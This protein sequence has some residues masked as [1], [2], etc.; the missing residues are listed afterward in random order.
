MTKKLSSVCAISLVFLAVLG[1][2]AT[3]DGQTWTPLN[4]A[5]PVSVGAMLLLTDGRVLVHEEPNCSG[6]GCVSTTNAYN[7]WYTLTPDSTGSY[8]NGTWAQVASTPTSPT[9]Y[10]P[11]FFSSAV[12]PDGKVAIQG[13]EYNCPSANCAD[14][15]QSNGALYDPAANTWTAITPE[16]TSSYEA[17]GDAQ[18]VVLPN[19]TW[20]TAACCAY[21]SGHASFPEYYYFNESSLNFTNEA[22]ASDGE[23]TEFDESGWNLMPNGEVLMVNVYLGQYGSG[24]ADG[25]SIYNP[26]TNT[27][28][29]YSSTA[30]QLWDSGC[31]NSS[32]A[33]YELGP[34]M[35]M[36]NG[37]FF[38]TGASECEA[39]NIAT[40]NWSTNTWTAQGT[41]PNKNAA[42]DAPGATEINGNAIV[43]T[44][45]Y[46]NTFSSPLTIYEWNGTTL[47]TFPNVSRASSDS[48]YVTHLLVL[49]TGQIMFTDFSTTV[50]ILTSAGTYESA[51]Q[52]TISSAPF[53]LTAGQTYSIS[54]TQFNGVSTGASYGDDFQDNTNYPL[55]RIVNNGTGDVYYARTHGHSTMGVATG[56]TIVSTNFDVPAGMPSGPCELYVVGNGIPSAASPCDVGSGTTTTL[57]L[58]SSVNPSIF[59]Q[60]VTFTA[61][62]TPVNSPAPT[63]TVQFTANGSGITGCTAVTL[64]SGTAQ[65]ATAGLAIGTNAI[66]A[67][68]SGDSNYNGTTGTLSGGQI[69][70]QATTTTVVTSSGNPSV[71]E[72]SVTMTAT[73]S[74]QYGQVKGR[75]GQAKSQNI[76]GT[77]TWS[78]NTGCSASTVTSGNPGT[79]TCTTSSLAVGT[80]TITAT[81]SG[82]NNHSGSSGTLGQVV[83]Q[84]S[85]T[86]T[87]TTN[88][89]A[90]KVYNGS[91]TVAAT[92]SSGLAVTFT[93]A[94]SCSNSGAT[95]TMTSGAGTCSVIAN[96]AGNA[97]YS[98]AAQVTETTN[99]TLASQTITFTTPAPASAGYGNSFTVV[100]NGGGSGNSLVFTSSGSCSNSGTTY[101]MTS[102]TGTCSVIANQA[103]NGNYAAAAQVT[104]TTTAILATSST[105]VSSSAN[106]SVYSQPVT[107]TA[108]ISGQYGQVKG[109]K[110]QAKPQNLSGTVTWSGNTGCGTTTVTSG[111]PGTATC[112]TSSLAVGTDAITATYSGDSNHNGNSSTLS[113]GQVVSQAST[114]ATVGSSLNPSTYGQAVSFT[115][116]VAAV[117]PAGG[118]PTG[119]VQFT[120]DG[121]NVGSPVTLAS[122]SATSG[123]TSTLAEGTHTITAVYSGVTDYAAS[124]GTLSAGQT[125]NQAT[126]ATVV[127]SS[128]NPSISGQSVT[129]T[130]TI[131]GQYGLVK[132]RKGQAKSRNVTGTVAWSGNTGCSASTVTSGNPGTATCTTSTLPVG[133]DGITA[134]YSGD[135]NHAGS[136]GTLSEVVN[137]ATASTTTT[138]GSS[139]DPSTY[140]QAVSF[141][142]TVT[143]ATGTPTGTVQFSIDGGAFGS[144]A[145][146]VSGSATSGSIATLT[147]GTH[148][149]TAVYS[150]DTDFA[151]STGALGGGQVVSQ[152]TAATVVTSSVNPS[153]FGQSVTLTATI[154]GENGQV[155]R[156]GSA[157]PEN[158]TG[159]V[160]WSS[161]TGCGTTSV[162]SGNPGVATC[163]TTVLPV[164]N[165]TIT[166][167]YLG[168]SNHGSSTGTLSGGQ[169]VNPATASTTT[170]VG[171][172]LNPSTYGQAVSFTANVASGAGTP[173]G[174][175][176]FSIDGSAF[177]S[178]VTLASGSATSGSTSTLAEGTHTVTAVYAG[179]VGFGTSTGTL[180]GGQV[181]NQASVTMTVGSSVNPSVYAQSVTLTA[182]IGG[183]YG[184]V[185]SNGRKR[186]DVSGTV[187]WST[188][189]GCGT[190]TVTPGN[191]GVATCTTSSFGVGTYA[192]TATYSGDSNHNGSS[193]TLAG[194]QVVN[195]A[196]QTITVT[197]PAPATAT[198][199]SS[200]TVVASASS[201]LAITFTSAGACTNAGAT[202]TMNSTKVGA[203][204]VVGIGQAGNADY[205]AASV[206]ELTN[207]AAAIAP[208]VTFTGA[209]ASDTYLS[210]FTVATT[211]NAS[212][213][214]TITAAPSTVC[215]ISGNVVTMVNGTGT[216]T[217]TAAWAADD[218]YKAATATQK[219]IAAKASSGLAWSTPAAITYGTLLSS[220]Q[221]DATANVAGTFV[222]S[223]AAGTKPKVPVAP[224]TCDTLKVTFTPTLATDYTKQT[225]TV[226]LVVNP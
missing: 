30:V 146:L 139:S 78:S 107:L 207:V 197:V 164:G 38:A 47:S 211:T 210:T 4:N 198:N 185:K 94:G 224:A 43:V 179:V 115:A 142:A 21:Y 158:V 70:N 103:G 109:R 191:P 160:A 53:N 116:N 182:T 36:P 144:P 14:A 77:V 68:Y 90:S 57:A 96:Q 24:T 192:I 42:N 193:A 95:Y 6:S 13:G 8:I 133:T 149:V 33:S 206:T 178:P 208:T 122:G 105:A 54:G 154:S 114:N 20:M 28:T 153:V 220:V 168:D 37:T 112:T 45:P 147:Q 15:W 58:S 157:K 40:Y 159:S 59:G 52:P 64:T 93:S 163:T 44:S 85:Q 2:V 126:A 177:G 186:Q 79:A 135:S 111:T 88:A 71:F 137:Q 205:A 180:S 134:T 81:Y 132:G 136:T 72:Q 129:L 123:S 218:K 56:S 167:T 174:T 18:S 69:V 175:V 10:A 22:S 200:F 35:L 128:A 170:T 221:L 74:G 176:Q 26:S 80:D 66:V 217:L 148:T 25:Y 101:T 156:N 104:E 99:A 75:K 166:A 124:T 215:T 131:S 102:G 62:V 120:V 19:G 87:F 152:A 130:A 9:N 213:T 51:W 214:P 181:V 46:T 32:K 98:A 41:F 199:K 48:S 151:T 50:E 83:S 121:V 141:T 108:T 190:T 34:I 118:T 225:A 55:V 202:Y 117:A 226:C 150:G 17:D 7:N 143:T 73:I 203:T 183:E 162:A 86:I 39:G 49:P 106:P 97:N 219:T 209:P 223:P 5:P 92:A 172:S 65:C 216:C 169:V 119:T 194:G 82:D 188:N 110:G 173:T 187:T 63:G 145:A 165:D 171:S 12:L 100:A 113:G 11:L 91:F 1:S 27:W 127:T 195:Q 76:S 29:Q 61:T 184:L 23:T 138:V 89:P 31:G 67:T 16:I 196:S 189:T 3:S 201:G 84:A 60:T 140:G 204:C 125:V 222:Y 155:K 212:T 161:N